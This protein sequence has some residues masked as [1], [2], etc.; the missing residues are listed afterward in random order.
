MNPTCQLEYSSGDA[1]LTVCGKDAVAT[2]ADCGTAICADC[3]ME[4]CG[5]LFCGQCYEYH[6]THSCV[7]KPVQN[8]RTTESSRFG[9]ASSKAS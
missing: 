1:D 3:L 8:E 6:A 9:S 7:K 2:C 5:D 4:C